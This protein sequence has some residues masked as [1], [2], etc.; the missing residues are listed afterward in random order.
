[1]DSVE[2]ATKQYLVHLDIGTVR[3]FPNGRHNT[4][5][6]SIGESIAVEA[7]RL[8][9]RIG[10]GGTIRLTELEPKFY[11]SFAQAVGAI[12][13]ARFIGSYYVRISYDFPI[14]RKKAV[15]NLTATLQRVAESELP[16][17]REIR[18]TEN[19]ALTF[20]PGRPVQGRP[21]LYGGSDCLSSAGWVYDDLL[22]SCLDA[23]ER[24][25][26]S[27]TPRVGPFEQWWLA[28][29]GADTIWI[30]DSYLKDL[31]NAISGSKVFSKL[32]LVNHLRPQ[33]SCSVEIDRI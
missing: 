7:T 27:I 11:Q 23:I 33:A 25:E 22:A 4:P 9:K 12:S 28:V 13:R 14:N 18:I 31:R 2:Y 26:R 8:V 16:P 19:M 17:P 10:Q 29:S 1:M 21:Y 24:K 5:D 6:F 30:E 15:R 3:E 32:L 20:F